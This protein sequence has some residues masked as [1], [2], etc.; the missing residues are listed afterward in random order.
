MKRFKLIG[1][2]V[3]T[4]E[5]GYLTASTENYIDTTWLRQGYH[6]EPDKLRKILQ[7]NIDRIESDDDPYTCTYGVGE[8]DAILLCY[9]LCSNGICGI[10]S[11]KYPIVV[12]RGHDCIT[13]L[14]GDKQ[15]YKEYFD[16]RSGGIYWYTTGWIENCLMPSKYR[17]DRTRAIYAEHYGE[18]NADYLLEMDS[19]WMKEY[20]AAAFIR[21]NEIE[22]EDSR[23]KTM[24]SAQYYSWEY[25]EYTGDLGLLRDLLNGNW[26]NDRFL[27]VN[28][29]EVIGQ[30]FDDTIITATA[31]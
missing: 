21:H 4:R 7:E 6:N 3:M 31:P 26:D 13:L 15:R 23:Q 18:E 30:S 25:L 8:F 24:E 19:G 22:S 1:C 14:L 2:K 9:G 29:G 17:E 12:P 10:H 5:V 20:R 28:P 16:E 27:V 11:T